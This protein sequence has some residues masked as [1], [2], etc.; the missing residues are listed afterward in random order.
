MARLIGIDIGTY[1]TKVVHL[2]R[3][4]KTF[5]VDALVF[6]TPYLD[7]SNGQRMVDSG[8]FWERIKSRIP[9]SVLAGSLIGVSLVSDSITML[10]LSLPKMPKKELEVSAVSEAKRKMIPASGPKSVFRYVVLGEKIVGTIPRYEIM[11]V[12][13]EQDD[14]N[15]IINIFNSFDQV[16]PF[17]ITPTSCAIPNLFARETEIFRENVAF[18]SIGYESVDITVVKQGRLYLYR[19]INFGLKDF[20]YNFSAA[21]GMDQEAM[22]YIVEREGVPD[23]DIKSKDR[24]QIAEEI[25]RQKYEA[26]LNKELQDKY[27]RLELRVLWQTEIERI[28]QEIRRTFSYYKEQSQGNRI[29][30]VFFFGGG[31]LVARLV[32]ILSGGIGGQCEVFDSLSKLDI[33]TKKERVKEDVKNALFIPALSIAL[34]LPLVK[35]TDVVIDFLPHV[36]RDERRKVSK[37]I[38][39]VVF[40]G[41]LICFVLAAWLDF[42]FNNIEAEKSIAAMRYDIEQVQKISSP[43]GNILGKPKT[44][45]AQL[46]KINQLLA[47]RMSVDSFLEEVAGAVPDGVVLLNLSLGKDSGAALLSPDRSDR[48]VS[49][50]DEEKYT[51]VIEASCLSDYEQ[52]LFLAK[53][54][55]Q[56]VEA[57]GT[58]SKVLLKTPELEMTKPQIKEA[59]TVSLTQVREREFSLELHIR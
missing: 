41:F 14:I 39:F 51:I 1:L 34:T 6:K 17:F 43:A 29:E 31:A 2:E 7:S 40:L 49:Q 27:N 33:I 36:L 50:A 20:I 54:F 13:A 26:S 44:A 25:M 42:Y 22:Q 8:A 24:V 57:S 18:V 16:S 30:H 56:K 32:P 48:R 38:G 53:E 58:F 23:I 21:L 46:L 11:V 37:Q 45:E 3:D 55:K 9:Q 10:T 5:L 47:E 19:T 35:K 52:A 28:I 12:R 59:G 15:K 4:H